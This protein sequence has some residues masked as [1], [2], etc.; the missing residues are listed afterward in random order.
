M[1]YIRHDKCHLSWQAFAIYWGYVSGEAQLLL[2]GR[3]QI[4]SVTF[5][6]LRLLRY[7]R[8]STC[9]KNDIKVNNNNNNNKIKIWKLR[10]YL[11]FQLTYWCWLPLKQALPLRLIPRLDLLPSPFFIVGWCSVASDMYPSAF[12]QFQLVAP[13]S[14]QHW[15]QTMA[16]PTD[17][18]STSLHLTRG[19]WRPPSNTKSWSS[20]KM[21]WTRCFLTM[22]DTNSTVS[23]RKTKN[24]SH[25]QKNSFSS[26]NV[27]TQ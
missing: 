21:D 19:C 20:Q 7:E 15:N 12:L 14:S 17:K 16:M 5:H 9:N 11:F 1:L 27:L 24:S 2:S 3:L 10:N 4:F 25:P 8:I 6:V 13:T 23:L 22:I 18:P 26:W